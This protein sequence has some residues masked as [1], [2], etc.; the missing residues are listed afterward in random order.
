VT[1]SITTDGT[2]IANAGVDR[3]IPDTDGDGKETVT[4][5]GSASSDDGTIVSYVWKENDIPLENANQVISE[6]ELTVGVHTIVL[7]V[8]DDENKVGTDNVVITIEGTNENPVL[9]VNSVLSVES[10][11]PAIITD[12]FLKVGDQESD[13]SQLLYTIIQ[14]PAFGNIFLDGNP[15]SVNNTFT[16]QDI[17]QRLVTYQSNQNGGNDSFRFTVTDGNGGILENQPE[18]FEISYSPTILE[19]SNFPSSQ[20]INESTSLELPIQFP[21]NYLIHSATF[22][23]VGLSSLAEMQSEA[24]DTQDGVNFAKSFN[25]DELRSQDEIG[26]R[27]TF[28][29]ID[30]NGD[31]LA[32]KGGTTYWVYEADHFGSNDDLVG[33]WH[34]I[35]EKTEN[36]VLS[37]FN[38]IAFPFDTQS[39]DGVIEE[40]LPYDTD[41]WRL[42]RFNKDR[43]EFIEYDQ[44]GFAATD[45]FEPLHGYFLITRDRK[46]TRF[47][48][49]MAEMEAL[50]TQDHPMH[51]ITLTSGWNLIGNPYP[52][53]LDWSGVVAYNNVE[54]ESIAQLEL[55]RSGE[56]ENDYSQS[57]SQLGAFEAAFVFLNDSEL[58]LLIPPLAAPG[59]SNG[60][61]EQEK[62]ESG[63]DL[64]I[65]LHWKGSRSSRNGVGMRP[66]A[67][68]GVDGFDALSVPKPQSQAEFIVQNSEYPMNRSIVSEQNSYHWQAKIE[69]GQEGE[70]VTLTWD[71]SIVQQLPEELHLWDETNSRLVSMVTQGEYS[72]VI[73]SN[74]GLPLQIYY[75]DRSAFWEILDVEQVVIGNP[76]PNP[77]ES[78][79]AI[80][81]TI[82]TNYQKKIVV[83]VYDNQGR[84]LS[85]VEPNGIRRGYQEVEVVLPEQGSGLYHYRIETD[86]Q[87]YSG[88][89]IKR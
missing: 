15:L 45:N 6:V 40:L 51:E 71:K 31:L 46:N 63:W 65:T 56:G 7:E 52:F 39:V 8:T 83:T 70:K 78:M 76:F 28:D 88:R 13:A 16:Q 5:D 26:I 20:N 81:L 19:R 47:G 42:F 27:Y 2:P 29:F 59:S 36:F 43:E 3:T 66:A 11:I 82:P 84:M 72:S 55:L 21:E 50:D 87:V 4:L 10:R 14:A 37:D 67:S 17:N 41:E 12:Q 24:L 79:V 58:N 23:Y 53:P 18:Q 77:V 48:G 89:L 75:G 64:P 9:E 1:I 34:A 69:G 35:G 73:T 62:K 61:V 86:Q 85:Q 49:Q 57:A 33:P 74:E 22:R 44:S 32:S 60:R 25:T 68:E 80:P 54:G 38:L 30:R